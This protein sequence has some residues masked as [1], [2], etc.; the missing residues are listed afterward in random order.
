[1]DRAVQVV[2]GDNFKSFYNIATLTTAYKHLEYAVGVSNP[3]RVSE[4]LHSLVI[5]PFV[6]LMIGPEVFTLPLDL[7]SIY[8][9]R[10]QVAGLLLGIMTNSANTHTTRLPRNP[11]GRGNPIRYDQ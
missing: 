1:M 6:P 2:P 9:L 11:D 10:L 3:L 5:E 4:P 8:E 7:A